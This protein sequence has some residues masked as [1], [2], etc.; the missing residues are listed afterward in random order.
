[1]RAGRCRLPGL[2]H[3][4]AQVVEGVPPE[5]VTHAGEEVVLLLSDVVAHV[6]D[7]DRDLGIEALVLRRHV[8]KLREHPLHDVVLLEALEGDVLGAG[9]RGAHRRIEQLLLD[10][11]VNRQRLGEAVDDVT[12]LDVRPVSGFLEAPEELLYPVV[13]V[14]EQG[15]RVHRPEL[16]LVVKSQPRSGLIPPRARSSS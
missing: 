6:L 16:P 5:L 10:S 3:G 2:G 8:V 12:L 15:Y 14:F 11:G 7:Q 1:V 9:H 13:V 4:V